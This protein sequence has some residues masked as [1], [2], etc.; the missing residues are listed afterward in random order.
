MASAQLP[1]EV[2]LLILSFI[3]SHDNLDLNEEAIK[4]ALTCRLVSKHFKWLSEHDDLWHPLCWMKWVWH[5][6]RK[7]SSSQKWDFEYYRNRLRI[8]AEIRETLEQLK[9]ATTGQLNLV[10][11]IVGHREAALDALIQ[12]EDQTEGYPLSNWYFAGTCR[13]IVERLQAVEVLFQAGCDL[14][15]ELVHKAAVVENLALETQAL[16]CCAAFRTDSS[17]YSDMLELQSELKELPFIKPNESMRSIA[18][19]VWNVA[20]EAGY[21]P[22][23]TDPAAMYFSPLLE[24]T[25][26]E[27]VAGRIPDIPPTINGTSLLILQMLFRR[28]LH[29]H[30]IVSMQIF[31]KFHSLLVLSNT[32]SEIGFLDAS[33][34]DYFSSYE[35]LRSLPRYMSQLPDSFDALRL[36]SPNWQIFCHTRKLTSRLADVSLDGVFEN[37]YTEL[38]LDRQIFGATL[39]NRLTFVTVLDGVIREWI[40]QK[41]QSG[42]F[43]FD[44]SVYRRVAEVLDLQRAT[45]L[46]DDARIALSVRMGHPRISAEEEDRLRVEEIA[47]FENAIAEMTSRDEREPTLVARGPT[48]QLHDAGF[49]FVKNGDLHVI[50]EW[51]EED[52]DDAQYFCLNA[53][54]RQL[55]LSDNDFLIET[56]AW[57]PLVG[58]EQEEEELQDLLRMEH[59][60]SRFLTLEGARLVPNPRHSIEFPPSRVKGM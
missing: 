30:N 45:I 6:I 19:T 5:H 53:S 2:T 33:T 59:V 3:P 21:L 18:V 54:G 8:D 42:I 49:I 27:A 22:L 36:Q 11:R 43:P 57:V 51:V 58:D 56:S 52:D 31:D 39:G 7:E 32:A 29:T 37:E 4:T 47:C 25:E 55:F 41:I 28:L 14:N 16:A 15:M 24:E 44:R 12:A 9:S 60:K 13:K 40:S 20:K 34:G 38:E 17:V 26:F 23:T 1:A 50:L 10:D 35:E 48:C 46:H